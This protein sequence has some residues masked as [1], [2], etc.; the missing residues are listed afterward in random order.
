MSISAPVAVEHRITTVSLLIPINSQFTEP[1]IITVS[2]VL[3]VHWRFEL[4]LGS[5]L[6]LHVDY[7]CC[8]GSAV[9]SYLS[10]L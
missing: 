2:I 5:P 8:L 10:R 4:T 7:G 9:I 3:T 6:A 1:Y